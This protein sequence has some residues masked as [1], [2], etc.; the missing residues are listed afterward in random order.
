MILIPTMDRIKVV[1]HVSTLGLIYTIFLGH[2]VLKIAT[3]QLEGNRGGVIEQGVVWIKRCQDL[4]AS[5]YCKEIA[6]FAVGVK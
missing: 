6:H 2:T 5:R 4:I 3:S 1:N